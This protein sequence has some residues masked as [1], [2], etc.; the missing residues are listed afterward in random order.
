MRWTVP[1][2]V[3]VTQRQGC[4]E[5][6]SYSK[7]WVCLFPQHGDG[8]KCTRSIVLEP[9][10][11]WVA[12]ERQPHMLLRGLIHSDGCRVVNRVCGGRYEYIRYMFSNRSED[13]QRI[14]A[15]ACDRAG[16]EWRR[17]YRYTTSVSKRSSVEAMEKFV[18][19]KS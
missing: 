5:I 17:S 7:H 14:F 10:Q 18:G 16:I 19:P 1:N 12:V 2:V 3:N 4:K 6:Y 8:R 9:W 15:T 11:E 13:I